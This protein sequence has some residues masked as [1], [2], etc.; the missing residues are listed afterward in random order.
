[1]TYATLASFSPGLK[2]HVENTWRQAR[3]WLSVNCCFCGYSYWSWRQLH[4]R[5]LVPHQCAT[6]LEQLDSPSNQDA[7]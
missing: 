7:L 5:D 6:W 3:E 4:A 2:V 1:M